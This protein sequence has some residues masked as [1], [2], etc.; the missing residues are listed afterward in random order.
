LIA[1]KLIAPHPQGVPDGQ[2]QHLDLEA[3]QQAQDL[4]IF[5]SAP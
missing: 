4:Y 1:S 3:L 5:P 2:M